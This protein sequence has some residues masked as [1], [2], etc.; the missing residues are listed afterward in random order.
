MAENAAGDKKIM[1]SKNL[2]ITGTPGVGKTTVIKDAVFPFKSSVRGFVTEEL[3]SLGKRE[4]F[5]IKSMDG[6]QGLFASKKMASASRLNK[7]GIDLEVLE[8]IGVSSLKAGLEEK[9]IIVIDEIGSME[10][11]SDVFRKTVVE[12]MA[13]SCPVLATMRKGSKPFTESISRMSHTRVLALSRQNYPDAASEVKEWVK[14][15]ADKVEMKALQAG[16]EG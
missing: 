3:R 6:R 8:L 4:G 10:M 5:V 2:I 1:F 13:S 16:D 15:W 7:Y 14:Y 12:C 9:K 11:F